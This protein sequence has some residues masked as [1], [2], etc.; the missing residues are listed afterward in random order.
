MYCADHEQTH[1][2]LFQWNLRDLFGMLFLWESFVCTAVFTNSHGGSVHSWLPEHMLLLLFFFNSLSVLVRMLHI[3]FTY[4]MTAARVWCCSWSCFNPVMCSC[5]DHLFTLQRMY[6][7]Y[8]YCYSQFCV[9][10]ICHKAS[11][12]HLTFL[13]YKI[14]PMLHG[15]SL[16]MWD[17]SGV[18]LTLMLTPLKESRLPAWGIF[19]GP[20][21]RTQEMS[22]VLLY[23]LSDES[24][25]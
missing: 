5:I 1:R 22:N 6:R 9:F 25:L 12:G 4:F 14:W 2:P 15:K 21:R 17:G 7:N 24:S 3:I 18:T 23:D 11:P 20:C 19:Y 16:F 8:C 13:W 10:P